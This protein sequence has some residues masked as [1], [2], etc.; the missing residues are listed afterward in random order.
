MEIWSLT[1]TDSFDVRTYDIR[2]KNYAKYPEVFLVENDE[3][4]SN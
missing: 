2:L 3:D 1:E 4:C